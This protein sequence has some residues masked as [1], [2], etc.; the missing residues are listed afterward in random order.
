L[1]YKQA[2]EGLETSLSQLNAINNRDG[3]KCHESGCDA[4]L[5]RKERKTEGCVEMR[6]SNEISGDENI[7]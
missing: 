1:L 4:W 2:K 7:L 5:S 6:G 3:R